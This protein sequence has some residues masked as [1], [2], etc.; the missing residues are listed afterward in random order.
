MG[1]IFSKVDYVKRQSGKETIGF[2]LKYTDSAAPPGY[3]KY[4]YFCGYLINN[5]VGGWENCHSYN[6]VYVGK[7]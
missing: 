4:A 5:G 2:V 6:K 1:G 3:A 7:N